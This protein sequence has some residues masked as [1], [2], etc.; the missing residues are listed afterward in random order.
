MMAA[1]M[2]KLGRKMGWDPMVEAD[3]MGNRYL[4]DYNERV[5][6]LGY[7]DSVAQRLYAKGQF[8]LDRYNKLAGNA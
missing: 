1:C 7:E 8:W 6:R 5:E 3:D 2:T 4:G